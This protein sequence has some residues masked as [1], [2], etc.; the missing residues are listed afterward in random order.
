MQL[1]DLLKDNGGIGAI[2]RE[3]GVPET[4]AVKGASA[5]LPSI[6]AGLH[7]VSG[8]DGIGGLLK[9][10]GG[11]DLMERVLSPGPTDASAGSSLLG[12][13]F[14]NETDTRAVVQQAATATSLDAGM[15]QKMLPLLT[16]LVSGF[17]AKQGGGLGGLLGNLSGTLGAGGLGTRNPLNDLLGKLQR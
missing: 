14:G 9:S 16:M 15:L 10:V 6:L 11:G 3:L 1:I 5:L 4:D 7:N 8:S 12:K 17:L 13:L 2:A